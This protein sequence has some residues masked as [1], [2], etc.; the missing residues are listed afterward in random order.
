MNEL[1]KAVRDRIATGQ[2][3]PIE[4]A[5]AVITEHDA[6]WLRTNLGEVAQNVIADLARYLMGTERRRAI[7][8]LRPRDVV[9]QRNIMD[10][11][12]W[13]PTSDGYPIWKRVGDVTQADWLSRAE[14]LDHLIV[15]IRVHATWCREVAKLLEEEGVA[16]TEQLRAPL[17]PLPD[18]VTLGAAAL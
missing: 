15:G 1:E 12:V 9:S 4:I 10:K 5:R 3:D 7:A 8:V 13:I 11:S 17:P 16:V 6:E 2:R 18:Q 14:Y